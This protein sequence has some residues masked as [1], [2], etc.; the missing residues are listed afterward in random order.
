MIKTKLKECSV[1]HDICVLW[2]STPKMCKSC[3]MALKASQN[4]IKQQMGLTQTT[5]GKEANPILAYSTR[6]IKAMST[7][8]QKLNKA[9]LVLREQFLKTHPICECQITCDGDKS[10]DVHHKRGRGEYLLED[11]YFL[12]VCRKCHTWIENSPN[13]AK[14][15]GFSL[16]RLD[17]TI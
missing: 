4:R 6:K 2:T 10:T 7:R 8:Q 12:A 9:Y 3:A 14:E 5:D 1:C 15:L 17:K 13:V 11:R 16:N